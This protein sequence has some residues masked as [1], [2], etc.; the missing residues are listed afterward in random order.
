MTDGARRARPAAKLALAAAALA[1]AL[2]GAELALRALPATTLGYEVNATGF[3]RPREFARDD[4]HNTLGMHDVEPAPKAPGARRVV[5]LGDSYVA[6]VSVPLA[7]GVARRL[8]AHL[9]ERPGL[10]PVD[11]VALGKEG[12]GQR[13]ELAALAKHGRALAPDLVL[14]LF[15][16]RNDVYNDAEGFD[17]KRAEQEALARA[18]REGLPIAELVPFESAI[19][20][21]VRGSALNQLVAHRLTLARIRRDAPPPVSFR[22]FAPAY[23]DEWAPAW[24]ATERLLVRIER[25]ARALGAGFAV[26]A[27]STPEGV[28]D[29][30]EGAARLAASHPDYAGVAFDVDLVDAR[31]ARLCAER[32]FAFAALQPALRA[33]RRETGRELHWRYDGHWNAFGN[34]AAARL[35]AELAAERLGPARADAASGTAAGAAPGDAG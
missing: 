25:R 29:P 34:D 4:A 21:W 27:A 18:A 3:I 33:L 12:W 6:A 14:L 30:A 26:A 32:G 19:G 5:L 24:A 23:A 35:L 16:T 1:L 8:E 31:L 11:V 22:A 20:L 28:L 17:A 10:G 15:T 2:V 7:Q 9:H 13:E